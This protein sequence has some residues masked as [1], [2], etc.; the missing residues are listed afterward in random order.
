MWKMPT[1]LKDL[2]TA[3]EIKM[4]NAYDNT[5]VDISVKEE[6]G[7]VIDWVVVTDDGCYYKVDALYMMWTKRG[8]QRAIYSDRYRKKAMKL[9]QNGKKVPQDPGYMS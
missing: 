8:P 4:I 3:E 5:I 2:F 1:S 7:K 9:Y 6:N